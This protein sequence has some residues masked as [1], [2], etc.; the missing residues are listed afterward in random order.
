MDIYG[1]NIEF[2]NFI[3]SSSDKMITSRRDTILIIGI[4]MTIFFFLENKFDSQ[5]KQKMKVKKNYQLKNG[6]TD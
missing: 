1:K 4:F 6:G 5:S 2:K 3:K